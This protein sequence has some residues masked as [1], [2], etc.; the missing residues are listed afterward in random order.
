MLMFWSTFTIQENKALSKQHVL[1]E[2]S[3]HLDLVEEDIRPYRDFTHYQG[4]SKFSYLH[5]L[6]PPH[7]P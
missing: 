4:S 6:P 2:V 1:A 7:G 3:Q 5:L